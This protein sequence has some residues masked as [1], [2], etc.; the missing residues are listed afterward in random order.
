MRRR[1]RHRGL[2]TGRCHRSTAQLPRVPGASG[3]SFKSTDPTNAAKTRTGRAGPQPDKATRTTDPP[4][5]PASTVN[6]NSPADPGVYRRPLVRGVASLKR[7]HRVQADH[8]AGTASTAAATGKPTRRST[9]SCSPACPTTIAP[10]PTSRN[11]P[12]KAKRSA[13]SPASRSATSPA[14]S[15]RTCRPAS[16]DQ[17]PR[18][19]GVGSPE[20]A[21]TRRGCASNDLPPDPAGGPPVVIVASYERDPATPSVSSL[22]CPES[23]TRDSRPR[24]FDAPRHTQRHHITPGRRPADRAPLTSL[25]AS[26]SLGRAGRDYR[27]E[28][29]DP[30][31][32]T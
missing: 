11:A 31:C 7:Q 10:R 17:H 4:T 24:Y 28:S 22:S 26:L 5:R 8:A 2:L 13:R 23:P 9:G 20:P 18:Q 29:P 16:P 12:P 25:R 27:A 15:T 1:H 14:R 6:R 30:K 19:V 21:H 32:R 3:A